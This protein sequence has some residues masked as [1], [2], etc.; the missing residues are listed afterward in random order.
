MFDRAARIRGLE[1]RLRTTH[2]GIDTEIRRLL[3][4]LLTGSDQ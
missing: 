1:E 2:F 4:A 3:D